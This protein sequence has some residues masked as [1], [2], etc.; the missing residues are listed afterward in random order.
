MQRNS[1]QRALAQ[2]MT[3]YQKSQGRTVRP[4][5]PKK[6]KAKDIATQTGQLDA[7]LRRLAYT[8]KEVAVQHGVSTKTV[9]RW[10]ARGLLPASK[11][12]RKLLIDA[13]AVENFMEVTI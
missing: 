6:D 4:G 13:R 7:P 1:P 5:L 10:V 8:V 2:Q 11:A 12:S 9:S 3:T